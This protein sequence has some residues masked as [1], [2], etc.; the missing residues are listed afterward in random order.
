MLR[1]ALWTISLWKVYARSACSAEDL[2]VLTNGVQ[3]AKVSSRNHSKTIQ[4]RKT[5]G[6]A[7]SARLMPHTACG[8]AMDSNAE[9]R[10][11][12]KVAGAKRINKEI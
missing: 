11:D 1:K 10:G 2:K 4:L 3:S 5:C 12:H 9:A 7:E 8:C 6:A